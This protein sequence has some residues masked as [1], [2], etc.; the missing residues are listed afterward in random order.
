MN[1]GNSRLMKKINCEIPRRRA[2]ARDTTMAIL[3]GRMVG[4][5]GADAATKR[6]RERERDNR[7]VAGDSFLCGISR[8]Q[9]LNRNDKFLD[10]VL[11]FGIVN[12]KSAA[13]FSS[14]LRHS[15]S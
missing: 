13:K 5:F 10:E 15:K 14:I 2:R 4:E 7:D 11:F 1:P 8:E 3:A 9:G 6:E 12:R